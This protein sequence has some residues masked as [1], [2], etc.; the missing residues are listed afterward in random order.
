MKN[1]K[2]TNKLRGGL[3][4][5]IIAFSVT[6]GTALTAKAQQVKNIVLVHGAFAD[7]SGWQG[8]YNILTKKGYHVTIVQ[9]PLSSLE[10]DVAA[11]NT[12]LDNQDGPTI[13]VG[14]S[15]GGVVITE[16][17]NHPKVA[18]L[19]YVAAVQPGDGETALK[20]LQTAPPA[21]ENGVLPPNDKGIIYYNKAKFHA[22]FCADLSTSEADF[23][24]A[25]QGAFYAKCFVT[26]VTH[27]AWKDKP[28]YGIVATEDK[29]I[30]PDIE[31]AMY[32][33]SNTKITE[34]KGS[35]V[36]FI[37]QPEAVAKV[38]IEAAEN[39]LKGK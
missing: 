25:S 15:W 31:R 26:P 4:T 21:P 12:V 35:H 24:Y 39:A 1:L 34:I 20:W 19:V 22:G 3:L 13:L 28:T 27:A 8:V 38:I 7:G 29:S 32:K 9:N 2:L 16:A 6:L 17:G 30:N 11:T 37:S 5:A 33:R 18:G 14:H 36:V 10:D 23:M